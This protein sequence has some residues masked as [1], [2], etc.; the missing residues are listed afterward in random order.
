ME[1][2]TNYIQRLLQRNGKS[3]SYANLVDDVENGT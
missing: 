1:K 3:S 2:I